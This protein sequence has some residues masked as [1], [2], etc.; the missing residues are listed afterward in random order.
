MADLQSAALAAWPR[1]R[2]LNAAEPWPLDLAGGHEPRFSDLAVLNLPDAQKV[3]QFK[4][5]G[6]VRMTGL[7]QPIRAFG[8]RWLCRLRLSPANCCSGDFG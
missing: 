7:I 5:R 3:R 1:R 4:R 8:P 6:Q 2:C